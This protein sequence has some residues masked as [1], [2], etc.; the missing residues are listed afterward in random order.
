MQLRKTCWRTYVCLVRNSPSKIPRNSQGRTESL[1]ESR[2]TYAGHQMSQMG[3]VG[4]LISCD[5]AMMDEL[6]YHIVFVTRG[7]FVPMWLYTRRSCV[8][9]S[10]LHAAHYFTATQDS[11]L[12]FSPC[13]PRQQCH[14]V[15]GKRSSPSSTN[16]KMSSAQ[17][18]H[19]GLK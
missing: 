5:T 16:F 13:H 1:N 18:G 17:L 8:H 10:P 9:S 15:L 4:H 7:L 6:S 12:Q 11:R 19:Q 2:P 14:P 3:P